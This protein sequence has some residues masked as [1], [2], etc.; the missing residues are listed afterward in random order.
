MKEERLHVAQCGFLLSPS[1]G[2][3]ILFK[4]EKRKEQRHHRNFRPKASI[5]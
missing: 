2:V 4:D 5:F 1:R 3:I